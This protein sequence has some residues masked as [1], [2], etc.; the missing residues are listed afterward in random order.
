ML[1]SKRQHNREISLFKNLT[2]PYIVFS[3]FNDCCLNFVGLQ[4]FSSYFL[5]LAPKVK[6]FDPLSTQSLRDYT[7]SG[8]TNFFRNH[9]HSGIMIKPDKTFGSEPTTEITHLR[10][11][12]IVKLDKISVLCLSP[13]LFLFQLAKLKPNF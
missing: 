10:T 8:F 1:S 7:L 6:D 9:I 12:S 5:K 4:R 2:H 13:F 3:Y 11:L